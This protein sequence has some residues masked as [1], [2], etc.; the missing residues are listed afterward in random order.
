M[1]LLSDFDLI[2]LRHFAASNN[3]AALVI[4]INTIQI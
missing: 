4:I 1:Y 3:T 2:N